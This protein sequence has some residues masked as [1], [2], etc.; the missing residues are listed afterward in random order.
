MRA[1]LPKFVLALALV[2]MPVVAPVA[3]L[4]AI[5]G[6]TPVATTAVATV[7]HHWYDGSETTPGA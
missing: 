1:R 4:A 6:A 2:S 3:V 5:G 7:P